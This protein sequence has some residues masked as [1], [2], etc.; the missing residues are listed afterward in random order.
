MQ[1]AQRHQERLGKIKNRV[2]NAHDYFKE[3]YDRYNEFIRFVFESNLS[4]DE[5]T[6]LQ[7][8]NRPQLEFNILESRISRLLGEFSKQEPDI[9][10][11][12]DDETKA[13]ALTMKVV[14]MHLRHTLLDIGNEHTRYEVYKDLL[15]GGFSVFKVYTDYANSMSMDQVINIKRAEPTLCVFDKLARLPHKGDGMFCAE[16]FPKSKEDF[17]EEFPDTPTNTLSFRRDF[18]GFNWSY[19]NDN[20]S[21]ILVA[22][23]Y[24]KV[25]REQTI[26]NVRDD[27]NPSGKVMTSQA[28]RKLLDEWDDI[29]MPP[30]QIGKPRKTTIDRIDRYRVIDNQVLEYEQTDYTMLPLV[31]VDGSSV[32]VKTPKNGNVRQVCRPYVYNAKGAQRLKNYAGIALANEIENSTQ[33][34]LMVAKEALPKEEDL[35]DA[36]KNPQTANVY[37]FNSVH[38]S[39]PE[40]PISNPIKEVQKMPCP[41]EIVQAFSGA[42]SL[43]EQ[44]LGSYDASLGI[45]NNQLSGVAIV[46]GA[47]QS[48]SAAMPYIVGFMQ[49][50]QRA[51]QIYV[52]L[53][54]KYYATPRTI[55]ILD[56]EGKRNSIKINTKDG[57]PFDFDTNALNIVVKAGASFQVQKARTIDMVKQVMQMSPEFANFIGTKGINFILEN[58]EGKGVE[59][60]KTMVEAWQQEQEKMKQQA[61]QM[62]QEE[63]QNNPAKM[64]LQV[65]MQKLQ[66]EAKKNEAQFAVDM[67]KIQL[68]KYKTE[69]DIHMNETSGSVQLVKAMTERL[70]KHTDLEIK[71]MDMSH[72]HLKEAIEVHHMKNMKPKEE[73]ANG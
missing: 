63:A 71:K 11:T 36:Y 48:N 61:M 24:E 5:I 72:R 46:E 60:L 3:N 67:E 66:M 15:A 12:A 54:P 50:L 17:E 9:Y 13:D 30:V 16:L 10:V 40:M 43:V 70:A 62:Q 73:R 27:K 35:L 25:K 39:N 31:F 45:N 22:D 18:A 19:I 58:V 29:T 49:G 20:S 55:P 37:V 2:R 8:I 34:K 26:V 1:V 4:G 64:K 47:T 6:L 52:D 57:V 44:V 51:A 56:E 41:P 38:E 42:D 14:E 23:Y 59:Q 65:D 69:A 28:Y 32:M 7:S 53:L 68:E 33:A 21:I